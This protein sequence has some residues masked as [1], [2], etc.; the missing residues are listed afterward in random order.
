MGAVEEIARARQIDQL[1]ARRRDA[2][3]RE[4]T[5]IELHGGR[6]SRR[7]SRALSG[8]DR[9]GGRLIAG[10]R[11]RGWRRLLQERQHRGG[12][13]L[14]RLGGAQHRIGRIEV[15]QMGPKRRQPADRRLAEQARHGAQLVRNKRVRAHA[16]RDSVLRG[17]G[18][19]RTDRRGHLPRHGARP[20]IRQ[21]GHVLAVNRRAACIHPGD[22]R[23]FLGEQRGGGRQIVARLGELPLDAAQARVGVVDARRDIGPH[24]LGVAQQLAAEVHA[25]LGQPHHRDGAVDGGHRR[26]EVVA[27]VPLRRV[28]GQ[29]VGVLIVGWMRDVVGERAGRA[30]RARRHA[31]LQDEP[32]ELQVAH[33][34]ADA[35]GS[36]GRPGSGRRLDQPDQ[37]NRLVVS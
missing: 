28:A 31:G 34:D 15:R 14:H 27:L 2:E 1:Q 10:S 16:D 23:L 18:V 22:P 36:S 3:L 19:G 20:P 12:A 26:R 37:A 33:A 8:Q 24:F 29:F 30:P 7:Q 21:I 25:T 13:A 32:G 4:G 5:A 11:R 9:R 6:P 17:S 35:A